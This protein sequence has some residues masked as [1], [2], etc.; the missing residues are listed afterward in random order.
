MS[1][2]PLEGMSEEQKYAI[3]RTFM[4]CMERAYERR[5]VHVKIHLRP[6]KQ[7]GDTE[8]ERKDTQESQQ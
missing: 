8:N 2:N 5:G 7:K 4:D 6:K 3:A 1:K